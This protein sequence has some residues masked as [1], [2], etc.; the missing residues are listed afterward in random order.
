MSIHFYRGIPV[1]IG[2]VQYVLCWHVL[3]RH[4]KSSQPI[5]DGVPEQQSPSPSA[6]ATGV[7]AI[8][9]QDLPFILRAA[10]L[11][12]FPLS[13]FKVGAWHGL[14]LRKVHHPS[15]TKSWIQPR[16]T[17]EFFPYTFKKL[18]PSQPSA[19]SDTPAPNVVCTKGIERRTF[20]GVVR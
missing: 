7:T 10:F 3:W 9:Y 4:S 5:Q 2:S 14:D 20:S 16:I 13:S 6:C 8:S 17:S 19:R 15:S 18:L 1:Q 12:Q 11:N